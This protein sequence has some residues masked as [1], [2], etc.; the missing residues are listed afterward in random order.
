MRGQ[1]KER[2][3]FRPWERL[4]K[5]S[6]FKRCFRDGKRVKTPGL[7]VVYWPNG[8]N[9]RRIGLSVGRRVGGSCVRNRIKRI[10]RE[11][12]RRNKTIFPQGHDYIFIPREDFLKITWKEHIE[13]L[14]DAF[15]SS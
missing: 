12:Y 2:E 15:S 5:S 11:L 10:I 14:R 8:L 13:H 9:Y 4:K 7:V 1:V 6:E 3:T